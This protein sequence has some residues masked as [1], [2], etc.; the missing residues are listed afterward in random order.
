MITQE[1]VKALFN[2]DSETGK[3]TNACNRGCRAMKGEEAGFLNK[4]GYLCVKIEK[5]Q[6]R[7]HRIIWLYVNGS[8]EDEVIDHINGDKQDNRIENLRCISRSGNA[9]NQKLRATNKSKVAGVH[10]HRATSKWVVQVSFDKQRH[11]G[12]FDDFFEAVCVRKSLE[13]KSGYHKNHGRLE[14]SI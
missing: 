9:K 13:L 14:T 3:L 5:K 1:E 7:A 12:C 2:Y 8:F 4:E 6:Y 11:V 10:W